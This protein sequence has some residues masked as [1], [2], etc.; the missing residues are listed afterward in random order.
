MRQSNVLSW[1]DLPSAF[2]QVA[3]SFEEIGR[4]EMWLYNSR[5]MMGSAAGPLQM[6]AYWQDQ[7]YMTTMSEGSVRV[8]AFP[9][10]WQPPTIQLCIK[11]RARTLA[12]ST[13]C[14]QVAELSRVAGGITGS[15]RLCEEL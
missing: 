15:L 2:T 14:G 6:V 5:G 11:H 4:L 13:V 3:S 8:R 10:L 12:V 1:L 9:Q 7:A